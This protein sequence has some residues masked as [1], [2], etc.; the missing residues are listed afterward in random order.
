MSNVWKQDIELSEL[1]ELMKAGLII[2]NTWISHQE[3]YEYMLMRMGGTRHEVICT[4]KSE[5]ACYSYALRNH[6]LGEEE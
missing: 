1:E 4:R 5:R 6:L 2:R 3:G